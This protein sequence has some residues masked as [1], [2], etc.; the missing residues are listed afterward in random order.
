M[1]DREQQFRIIH[2]DVHHVLNGIPVYL[3]SRVPVDG[4]VFNEIGILMHPLDW[5]GLEYAG[6]PHARLDAALEWITYGI[7]R[8]AQVATDSLDKMHT[9]WEQ[10][11]SGE[12]V[13]YP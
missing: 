8:Q 9:I 12:W 1:P 7:A 11:R 6:D 5:V 2:D 13:E 3:N 4:A 10:D